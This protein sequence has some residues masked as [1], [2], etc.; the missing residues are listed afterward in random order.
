MIAIYISYSP[1]LLPIRSEA[2][3][4]QH[5]LNVRWRRGVA[6]ADDIEAAKR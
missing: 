2:G 3:A 5:E 6:A 1:S 4:G